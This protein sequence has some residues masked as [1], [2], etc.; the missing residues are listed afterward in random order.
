MSV[1]KT[2][3]SL[4]KGRPLSDTDILKWANTTVQK[5]KS[6]ARPARSFKDPALSAGIWFLDLLEGMRPGIVDPSMVI[7][8]SET[9]DYDDRRQNGTL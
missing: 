3:S 9:G 1:T 5:A 7:N 8:V 6:G 4:S 2:M